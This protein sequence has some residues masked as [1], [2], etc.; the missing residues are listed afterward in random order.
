MIYKKWR[1]ALSNLKENT[2]ANAAAWLKICGWGKFQS[3]GKL[4][5]QFNPGNNKAQAK[6]AT[7]TGSDIIIR[8]FGP[9]IANADK[10]PGP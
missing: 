3:R 6:I 7:D 1:Y 9:A 8:V 5:E 10:S 2:H 4:S